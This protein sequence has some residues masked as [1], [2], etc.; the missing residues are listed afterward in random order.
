MTEY[1]SRAIALL[2]LVGTAILLLTAP[3]DPAGRA[4]AE[5]AALTLFTV[6]FWA[7]GALPNHTTALGFFLIAI[8]FT[9]VPASIVFAGFE[10][11]AFWL[12]FGG[13]AI[14]IAVQRTGLGGRLARA[15]V[16][17]FG[18][19]YWRVIA[20]L[21][22]GGIA[23]SFVMPSTMGRIVMLT[24]VVM[25]MADRLGLEPG[26][27]GRAGMV[28]AMCLGTFMPAAG[29]LPSNLA[30]MVLLGAA[31]TVHGV[32][33][34]YFQYLALHFPI[35]GLLKAV[36]IVILTV[37][38]FGEETR[39]VAEE[40]EAHKPLSRDE[41]VLAAILAVALA[42]WV[43]DFLHH[44]SPAWVALAAGF[45]CLLPGVRLVPPKEF[46]QGMHVGPLIYVG[47]I[48]GVAAVVAHSGLGTTLAQWVI[49][50]GALAPDTP[51]RNYASL[52]GLST[53]VGMAA[54]IGGV[55]AI[56][57]PLAGEMAR[58]GELPLMTVLMTQVLG[59]STI[60]LPYQL[61]P[62]VVGMQLGGVSM[63][64]GARLTLPLAAI[65]LLLVLPANYFWWRALGYL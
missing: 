8:L 2:A 5:A 33:I 13:L 18:T 53:L 14:G 47:G 41:K 60:I 38:L 12:V 25:A 3:G 36:F 28:L 52:F 29:I 32:T 19:D 37:R 20:G 39:P 21:V 34:T 22:A 43:T 9:A 61:P 57:T 48:L 23:L 24:P 54:T 31:E 7:T 58:A 46:E 63:H 62:L 65:T 11:T 17:V 49:E 44:I 1:L 26:G 10:S 59:F 30:N 27:R 56:M 6:T 50:S 35:L 64:E 40:A 42:F 45:V 51:V 16:G 15:M 4:I 55:P